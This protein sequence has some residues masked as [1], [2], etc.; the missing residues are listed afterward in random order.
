MVKEDQLWFSERDTKED[1]I[2]VTWRPPMDRREDR[3]PEFGG[4]C[5]IFRQPAFSIP[6]ESSDCHETLRWLCNG[7]KNVTLMVVYA[8]TGRGKEANARNEHIFDAVVGLAAGLGETPL[9]ICGDL[10]H[11]P[12]KQS[13]HL[14]FALRQG[15]LTD[16]GQTHKPARAAQLLHTYEQRDTKRAWTL[17]WSTRPSSEVVQR[18]L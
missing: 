8:H 2:N 18:N 16:L 5:V 12:R 17:H 11:E 10:Q 7:S 9:M 4:A 15:W 14:D 6:F 13:R 3:Q 1:R